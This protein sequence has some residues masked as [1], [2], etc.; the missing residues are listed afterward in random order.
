MQLPDVDIA[1]RDAK[2]FRAAGEFRSAQQALEELLAYQSDIAG[3]QHELGLVFGALG[4][5][6]AAIHA[7]IR[8]TQIDPEWAQA[9]SDLA[10]QY[11][12]SGDTQG[13]E[14]ASLRQF[15]ASIDDEQLR[16]AV[17]ALSDG[18]FPLAEKLFLRFLETH[19]DEI[20]AL[21]LLA[22]IYLNTERQADA[23]IL[24]RRCLE[25]EPN[26]AAARHR[27]AST[28]YVQARHR[29]A[30]EQVDLLLKD[31]PKN[32]RN[33]NLKAAVFGAIGQFDRAFECHEFL[34]EDFSDQPAAWISYG[35]ALKAV[36]RLGEAVVAY[37]RS[38]GLLPTL[39][40]AYWSLANLKQFRFT[41]DDITAMRQQLEN[42]GLS[43]ESR[44]QM[45]VALGKAFE[46]L[47]L[48]EKSFEHY[49]E[50]NAIWRSAISYDP[51]DT[52]EFVRRSKRT[53]TR[54]FFSE[55]THVGCK[56]PDPIFIVGMPRS[57]STLVEQILSSHSAIEGTMELP[58]IIAL[59]DRLD[60]RRRTTDCGSLPE[61]LANVSPEEF[62][63]LG[64]EYLDRASI[65]RR[66]ER[67]YFIDKMPNNFAY[68]GFIQLLLP[69]S[70]IIDV[71]RHPLACCFSNFKQHF[72]RG[73]V[74][75]YRLTEL[76]R[77]YRDYVELMAHFDEVLPGRVHRIL[78]ENLID[79]PEAEIR[80]LL[81]YCGLP[82]ESDCLRFYE[83]KRAVLTPSSEQVRN[84]IYRDG[85]NQWRN[86]ERWLSP[87]K[88]ALGPVLA[89]PPYALKA[90]D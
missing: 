67:P 82:F 7:L 69:N 63:A 70:K 24:L 20:N 75:T 11:L 37:R 64:E 17:A 74:F 59:A 22:E 36:G 38:I 32:A 21:K 45:H 43:T 2:A 84:P 77:Y 50:G 23:E 28:L 89:D 42:P 46:D 55:R 1:L 87:L 30:L 56:R 31:D 51:R 27:Y 13:A 79:E 14:H 72:A 58:H 39:G 68:T 66:S 81:N 86:Y 34:V 52:T 71:R 12:L 10:E 19:P 83:N 65:H 62:R 44:A 53:F 5:H 54:E 40:G 9:W 78:Y 49:R 16:E 18:R 88:T 6:K 61:A 26:F 85:L 35:H 41:A 73:Q 3:A 47:C 90:P 80:S 8:A 76:G 4:D 25:I 29:E 48:F 33:R 60:V 57:G 15:Y